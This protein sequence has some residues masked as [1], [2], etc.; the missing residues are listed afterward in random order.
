MQLNKQRACSRDSSGLPA[1]NNAGHVA[2][3][4][5]LRRVQPSAQLKGDDLDVEWFYA[6]A[7]RLTQAENNNGTRKVC[8]YEN[9]S[10]SLLIECRDDQDAL[11][12][13]IEF[14]WNLDNSVFSRTVTNKATSGTGGRHVHVRPPSPFSPP[15]APRGESHQIS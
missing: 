13:E 4:Q 6:E 7:N 1:Q 9:G 14:A 11:P 12:L 10:Q 8:D 2:G 5:K 3:R 15:S